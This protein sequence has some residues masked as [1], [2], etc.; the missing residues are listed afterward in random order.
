MEDW[1]KQMIDNLQRN[2]DRQQARLD[3]QHQQRLNRIQEQTNREIYNGWLKVLVDYIEADVKP[4]A[5][6]KR[7]VKKSLLNV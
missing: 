4:S 5:S 2:F 3:R 1:E 6:M 7:D